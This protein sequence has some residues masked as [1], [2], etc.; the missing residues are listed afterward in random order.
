MLTFSV[1]SLT[2]CLLCLAENVLAVLSGA[3]HVQM[4]PAVHA[5]ETY[6]C[7]H[8]TLHNCVELEHVADLYSL[9]ELHL[10]VR[11]F[12][13]QH[14]MQFSNMPDFLSL[15]QEQM[16]GVLRSDF[17]VYCPE[18]EVVQAVLAWLHHDLAQR[19]Y[20][21]TDLL[22]HVKP[23]NLLSA[24][25]QQLLVS[26]VGQTVLAACPKLE[27]LLLGLAA[28]DTET[29]PGVVNTRG[30]FETVLLAGGFHQ[31]SESGM[32]N[33]MMYLD[34]DSQKPVPYTSIPH[35]KQADFGLAVL[36]NL[37]YVVGGCY[38]DFTEMTHPYGFCFNPTTSKWTSLPPM[39][40]ER[41][42]F[43]FGVLNGMLYAVG[44]EVD[45]SQVL[46]SC[47]MF[48]PGR[49]VWSPI[50]PLPGS[51]SEL[52]GTSLGGKL[53]VSGGIQE[54]LD[55]VQNQLW[56]YHPETDSWCQCA[57]MLT[58]RADHSMFTYCNRIYVIGGWCKTD[59]DHT[60]VTSVDCYDVEMDRWETVQ[61][62]KTARRYCTCTLF[63]GR[64]YVIGGGGESGMSVKKWR[65]L[66]VLDLKTMQWQPDPVSLPSIW[67]HSTVSLHLPRKAV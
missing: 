5:C 15:S 51:R 25:V 49:A 35:V 3:N 62:M 7:S 50:A 53:Y 24:D 34:P 65:E 61:H 38:D 27:S 30:Y 64:V 16:V 57:P 31:V 44:G 39:T 45:N 52:A 48:D 14:W 66:D 63:Q 21:V 17:P 47:E 58:P 41:C 46:V 43:Y 20:S 36:D 42:R 19:A 55:R 4:L 8:L 28:Q 23:E 6:L 12:I 10:K 56:C 9:K 1:K 40:Q 18:V 11:C 22:A 67:E 33:D 37:V 60:P 26:P 2:V 54:Q 29:V 13:C 59:R 32:S